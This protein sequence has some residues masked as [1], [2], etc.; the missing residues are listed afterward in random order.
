MLSSLNK[1]DVWALWFR[2][3]IIHNVF[4]WKTNSLLIEF[5]FCAQTI[6]QKATVH[7][8]A[9]EIY[10]VY[11]ETYF[12]QYMSVSDNEK[13]KMGNKRDHIN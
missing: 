10:N 5:E 3:Y 11:L 9:S 6:E 4:F 8:N 7:D 13:R 12:Y 1:G 2:K